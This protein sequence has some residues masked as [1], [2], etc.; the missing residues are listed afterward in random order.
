M[1][2]PNHDNDSVLWN[3][4]IDRHLLEYAPSYVELQ[5]FGA[6]SELWQK[7]WKKGPL[8]TWCKTVPVTRDGTTTNDRIP[9]PT[10]FRAIDAHDRPVL[11]ELPVS[12]IFVRPEYRKCMIYINAWLRRGGI[13]T[14][15]EDVEEEVECAMGGQFK[16]VT[17]DRRVV[18][19]DAPASDHCHALVNHEIAGFADGLADRTF[20]VTGHPGIGKTLFIYYLLILRLICGLPTAFHIGQTNYFYFFDSSGVYDINLSLSSGSLRKFFPKGTW[21][22]VDGVISSL[23]GQGNIF[24]SPRSPF[25][26]V[27][28]CPPQHCH[29][30]YINRK[31]GSETY[32]ML[33]FSW[34]ELMLCRHLLRRPEVPTENDTSRW[35][36]RFG[37]S[38]RA[39][40]NQSTDAYIT[41]NLVIASMVT[42]FDWNSTVAC[43]QK[44]QYPLSAYLDESDSQQLFLLIPRYR[45]PFAPAIVFI[46]GYILDSFCDH[47]KDHFKREL[48]T[49][50]SLV[51][52][53]PHSREYLCH[54][55]EDEAN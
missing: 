26:V 36:D 53:H 47:H 48:Q 45:Y 12:G 18:G 43:L 34:K 5:T 11:D 21:A 15:F 13:P 46:S 52:E 33:P 23:E 29:L 8:N 3:C 32:Y 35:Y 2:T 41:H 42:R 4:E 50:F 14:V 31:I 49:I 25:F 9:I 37:P 20:V 27:H 7:L 1:S 44:N 10:T 51:Y 17:G 30:N 28:A 24:S 16:L 54:V 6:E 39:C 22:L 19:L 40:Y 55:F 38:A